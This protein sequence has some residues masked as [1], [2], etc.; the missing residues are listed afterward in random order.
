MLSTLDLERRGGYSLEKR[1]LSTMNKAGRI[2]FLLL[3]GMFFLSV[4]LQIF[5]AGLAIF[6]NPTHWM[7]HKSFVHL[8]GFNIPV[9]LLLLAYIGKLP[10][11]AY[12]YVFCLMLGVF[13]MYFT[14]N[15][16]NIIRWVGALHPVFS[17]FL[18]FISYLTLKKTIILVFREKKGEV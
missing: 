3:I 14:A 18:L 2:I 6:V 1:K 5:F 9:F 8:F 13:T 4:L 10:K 12:G 16:T 15:F 11:W 17:I 7:A